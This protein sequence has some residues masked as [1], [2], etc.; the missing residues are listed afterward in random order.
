MPKLRLIKPL[1]ALLTVFILALATAACAGAAG[2]EGPPGPPGAPGLPGIS[3]QPGLA[4]LQGVPGN[5]GSSGLQG[6]PGA[7]GVPGEQGP[8]GP[9]GAAGPAS[10]AFPT[11]IML[12]PNEVEEGRPRIKVIGSG[13][14]PDEAVAIEV[15]GPDGYHVFIGGAAAD[16]SGTFEVTIRPRRRVREGGPLKP[17]LHGV[18]ALGTVNGGASATLMVTS[19]PTIVEARGAV[20]DARAHPVSAAVL[21]RLTGSSMPASGADELIALLDEANVEKAMFASFGFHA[22]GAPDDAASSAE[23]D[24]TAEEVAKYPDRLIGFCGINPL[25]PGALEEIDRCLDLDGMVG[26]KLQIPISGVDLTNADHVADLLAVF[27]KAEEHDAPVQLH[28]QTPSVPPYAA[29]AS[30]NLAAIINAHPDVRV[31]H[32]H[33]GGFMDENTRQLWLGTMRPNVETSF[34]DLSD[35]LLL[36]EDAPI[37][38]R[39]LMVWMLRKWGIE[40]V[41]WSSDNLVLRGPDSSLKPLAA[42]ETLSKFPFTQKEMDII[43]NNDGSAW[44]SGK[45]GQ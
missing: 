18:V 15:Y 1:A 41:L 11:S 13:W 23:N 29:S 9:Q 5:P 44:L 33:C 38:K 26:I 20:F 39:E 37:S 42:L 3:G 34:L 4:G 14:Q 43:R 8:A 31:L 6:R 7:A 45:A 19:K 27:A 36:F 28:S 16:Q 10:A 25:Y 17:G 32:S 30:A 35:C 21:E 2:L 24:F 22:R 40:R 12:V